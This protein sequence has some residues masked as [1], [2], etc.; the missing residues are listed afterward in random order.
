MCAVKKQVGFHWHF[1]NQAQTSVPISHSVSS[2]DLNLGIC[3]VG[4][5]HHLFLK[6]DGE[7]LTLKKIIFDTS[8]MKPELALISELTV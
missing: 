7:N 6:N 1:H 3:V 5:S 2:S 8:C 4:T